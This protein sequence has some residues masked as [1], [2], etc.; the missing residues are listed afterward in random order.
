MS[1]LNQCQTYKKNKNYINIVTKN[2][3]FSLVIKK[4]VESEAGFRYKQL[5]EMFCECTHMYYLAG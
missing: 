3:K 4:S 2:L 1:T 5:Y